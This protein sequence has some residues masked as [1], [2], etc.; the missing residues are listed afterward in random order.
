MK[1]RV[2]RIKRIKSGFLLNVIIMGLE[3]EKINI[4]I[5]NEAY[6]IPVL[7]DIA[8]ATDLNVLLPLETLPETAPLEAGLVSVL[9]H[10]KQLI[11]GDLVDGWLQT[12]KRFVIN[13]HNN[14][15][16]KIVCTKLMKIKKTE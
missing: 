5:S 8:A 6:D 10:G 2:K 12:L 9:Q 7:R 11:F 3:L 14:L 1:E 15:Q 16:K 4:Y 13:Q